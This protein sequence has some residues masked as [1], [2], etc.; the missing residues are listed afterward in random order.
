MM[1]LHQATTSMPLVRELIIF[2]FIAGMASNYQVARVIG[3]TATNRYHMINVIAFAK[4]LGAVVTLALL[5]LILC[6]DIFGR[7]LSIR[8]SQA[9]A[10]V[11]SVCFDNL[12]STVLKPLFL[13]FFPMLKI[14]TLTFT[15][16]SANLT[17]SRKSP[18]PCSKS[19]LTATCNAVGIQSTRAVDRS[20][21]I[22]VFKRCEMVCLTSRAVFI[23]FWGNVTRLS[24]NVKTI[25]TT[26]M[27]PVSVSV[28]VFKRCRKPFL[29]FETLLHRSMRRC[30]HDLNCLSFSWPCFSC[31]QGARLHL[32]GRVNYSLPRQHHIV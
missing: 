21:G 2:A 9:C 27:E 10:A 29:A 13:V 26:R 5:P 18:I 32:F 6:A 31:C 16:G 19:S 1:R 25:L 3:T 11:A 30:I 28:E 14:G 4:F 7:V 24:I 12:I 22:E 17:L 15:S 23:S 8:L 20:R